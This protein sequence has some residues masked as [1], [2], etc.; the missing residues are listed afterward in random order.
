[1]Y[2]P[3]MSRHAVIEYINRVDPSPVAAAKRAYDCFEP[4]RLASLA[5]TLG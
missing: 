4:Y 1:M 2:S 5:V 3:W